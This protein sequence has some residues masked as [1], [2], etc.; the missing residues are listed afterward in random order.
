MGKELFPLHEKEGMKESINQASKQ[1]N[2]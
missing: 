1:A 2:K